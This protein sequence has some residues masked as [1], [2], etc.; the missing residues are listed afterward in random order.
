MF[1]IKNLSIKDYIIGGLIII[2]CFLIYKYYINSNKIKSL[3]D[4]INDLNNKIIKLNKQ[5]TNYSD[6]N[7]NSE[8]NN[9]SNSNSE[10]INYKT[11]QT[12]ETFNNTKESNIKK[13]NIKCNKDICIIKKPSEQKINN[14]SKEVDNIIKSD[15]YIPIDLKQIINNV[16]DYPEI[17]DDDDNDDD[18]N[19]NEDE[20]EY[21][22]EDEDD[23]E[24]DNE[25]EDENDNEN[26]ND[27]ENENDNDNDNNDDNDDDNNNDN[28]DVWE[29][30]DDEKLDNQIINNKEDNNIF[31]PIIIN[32][33]IKITQDDINKNNIIH[34]PDFINI[35]IAVGQVS[36]LEQSSNSNLAQADR[37]P[38]DILTSSRV[39]LLEQAVQICFDSTSNTLVLEEV[40]DVLQPIKELV[41]PSL[42][43]QSSN[44]NLDIPSINFE[45]EKKINL[46]SNISDKVEEVNSDKKNLLE[47]KS[48]LD[49]NISEQKIELDDKEYNSYIDLTKVSLV[50]DNS[51]KISKEIELNDKIKNMKINDIK[52]LAKELNI[53]IKENG[54]I[55]NKDQLIKEINDCK[56]KTSN[57]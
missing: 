5:I 52:N 21:E 40:K 11:V 29:N 4:D 57:I 33:L 9:Q 8:S 36:L 51:L 49:K 47:E 7:T 2:I 13:N 43:E 32:N 55:K 25:D 14:L 38:L 27:N 42:L 19:N 23:N 35:P 17:D 15:V 31:N 34:I 37:D 26:D 56:N 6:A 48:N 10:T 3:E 44:S 1:D 30:V 12:L 54:K 53:N 24:D 16:Y 28:D 39:S 41:V 50:N 46:E 20:D 45:E 18:N 22:D